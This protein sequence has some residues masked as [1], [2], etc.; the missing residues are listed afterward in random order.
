MSDVMTSRSMPSRG[1][2]YSFWRADAGGIACVWLDLLLGLPAIVGFGREEGGGR[3]TKPDLLGESSETGIGVGVEARE[4]DEIGFGDTAGRGRENREENK[5]EGGRR[6]GESGRCWKKWDGG[7]AHESNPALGV[8]LAKWGPRRLPGWPGRLVTG[9][10]GNGS[11]PGPFF[12]AT[13]SSKSSDR[14]PGPSRLGSPSQLRPSATGR[15]LLGVTRARADKAW[16]AASSWLRVLCTRCTVFLSGTAQSKH[17]GEGGEGGGGEGETSAG[18]NA[19]RTG[20]ESLPA[21]LQ[22][23]MTANETAVPPLPC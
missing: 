3:E 7:R 8:G 23:R 4:G 17:W 21:V 6:S 9:G 19:Q 16:T 15:L 5:N 2:K 22:Q 20:R 12:R 10:P 11:G 14:L 1:T 18:G 13:S